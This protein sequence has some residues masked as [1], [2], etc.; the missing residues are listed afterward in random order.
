MSL[1]LGELEHTLWRLGSLSAAADVGAFDIEVDQLRDALI[2]ERNQC[3]GRIGIRMTL[4]AAV[5]HVLDAIDGDQFDSFQVTVGTWPDRKAEIREMLME[6]LAERDGGAAL[7][8]DELASRQAEELVALE[9]LSRARSRGGRIHARAVK[10]KAEQNR[11]KFQ[12]LA[13]QHWKR[14]PSLTKSAVARLIA[15]E[16]GA[17]EDTVRRL[18]KTL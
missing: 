10:E 12:M 17:N 3:E 9:V 1:R 16:T 7:Q 5:N 14:F 2:D 15:L 18:I 4:E 6:Y 8:L 13:K 11:K